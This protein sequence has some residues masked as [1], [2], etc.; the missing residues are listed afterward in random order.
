MENK[1]DIIVKKHTGVELVQLAAS[2]TSGHESKITL[3]VPT[4]RNTPS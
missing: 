1:Y 2:F 4:K 3:N